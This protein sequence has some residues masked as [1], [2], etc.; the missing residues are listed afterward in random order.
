MADM[1]EMRMSETNEE[2]RSLL[3]L[4]LMALPMA[5]AGSVLTATAVRADD[6]DDDDDRRRRRYR[7]RWR[8]DDYRSR[9]RRRRRDDDDDD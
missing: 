6:D 7:G 9:R 2:R 5:I 4:A 8:D 3:R 1:E